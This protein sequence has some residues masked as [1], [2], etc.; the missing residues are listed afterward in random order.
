MPIDYHSFVVLED[1][2]KEI[3]EQMQRKKV[4][5]TISGMEATEDTE[6]FKKTN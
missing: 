2:V 6:F 4:Q 3:L 5:S 1:I